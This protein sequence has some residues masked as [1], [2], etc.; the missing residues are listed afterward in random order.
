[1]KKPIFFVLTVLIVAVLSSC[2][3]MDQNVPDS[4]TGSEL[5]DL[6]G[7]TVPDGFNWSTTADY[8]FNI[9]GGSGE[10]VKITSPD[11][12]VVYHKGTYIED[13]GSYTVKLRLPSFVDEIKINSSP[14]Y[15]NGGGSLDFSLNTKSK[16]VNYALQFD[17]VDDYVNLGDIVEL[18]NAS[19]FTIEGWANQASNTDNER[20]F[21]KKFDNDNYIAVSPWGGEFYIAIKNGN[22][23][24]AC[25]TDYSSTI[26]SNTWFHWAVVYDG[27]GVT[28]AD[29]LKLY[30]NGNTTPVTLVFTGTI[31]ST[32][33]AS[34]SGENAY[35]SPSAD[36]FGGYMD[37]VRIWSTARTAG[38][39]AAN[40]NKIIT[41]PA[42]LEAYYRMD[43]GEGLTLGD[44]TETYNGTISDGTW[45]LYENFF[46]SDDDGVNDLN[47]DYWEDPIRTYNNYYP[48]GDTGTLAFEDL[49]PGTGDYDFNDLVVG[50]QFKTVTNALNEVV[51]IECYFEI[52]AHGAEL[53][54]GFGFQLPDAEAS[55]INNIEVS[56]YSN[57]QAVVNL[58]PVTKLELGQS[59]PVVIVLDQVADKM[60]KFENVEDWK[61]TIP[62]VPMT[63]T[64]TVT[65]GGPYLASDFS[66]ETWNPFM[67]IDQVRGYEVHK[68]DYPPTDL[69]NPAYFGTLEDAS[70]PGNNEYY[71]TA[72]G[73]PWVLEFNTS[74]EYPFEKK[75]VHIAYLH[76]IEWAESGGTLFTDWYSNTAVDYRNPVYIYH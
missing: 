43:E 54:N 68:L 19:T 7:M 14:V 58:D 59:K 76:F 42:G 69:V 25:W 65:G 61:P 13:N 39:I 31:P 27:N 64:L 60:A 6:K 33:S 52:R 23:S 17:G 3:K 26:S 32:T 53:D 51:E 50:Y 40:Y 24:N 71:R 8:T 37:E 22:N 70:D 15:L 44:I 67:F 16:V 1:M 41:V 62:Y 36:F 63:V 10:T 66:V 29:K 47:D 45:V 73:L 75:Y 4:D 21:L 49:W 5:T 9:T 72:T 35:L 56:G 11:G 55:I 20:I 28:N 34:L 46:D 12:T 2:S 18:N 57:T 74:F 30:I 48:A 38:E